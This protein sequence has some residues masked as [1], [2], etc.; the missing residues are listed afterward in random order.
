HDHEDE[1]IPHE[2]IEEEIHDQN[3]AQDV[4]FEA[5]SASYN[6]T[7]ALAL[8]S[9]FAFNFYGLRKRI[10][11]PKHVHH[12]DEDA[13]DHPHHHAPGGPLGLLEWIA[14]FWQ[15]TPMLYRS[16]DG[17]MKL[18]CIPLGLLF[19]CL[20]IIEEFA[21]IL[22]LSI[23]LFGNISGEHQVKTSLIAT[24]QMFLTSAFTSLTAGSP[25]FLFWGLVAGLIWMAS[26]FATCLGALAGFIQAMIF[27]VLS[28]VYIAHAVADEH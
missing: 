5:P 12:H 10:F 3:L 28:L 26:A 9:F 19:I 13:H 21:R 1:A 25:L 16:L 8:I 24:M 15:P 4:T 18:L 27:A 7:L 14:H 11:P 6:T 17:G 22:S 20:N 2:G 23:R